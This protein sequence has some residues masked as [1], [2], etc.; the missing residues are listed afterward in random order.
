M[1]RVLIADDHASF[2]RAVSTLLGA[3]DEF[4]VVGTASDGDEAVRRALELQPD[5]VLMDIHMPGLNGID[6]THRITDAAPHIAVLVLTMFDADDSVVAAIRAGARGYLLKGSRQDELAR[7]L[8]AVHAGDAIFGAP[9]AR[10][11][12]ALVDGGRAETPFPELSERERDVLNVLA[13]GANNSAIAQ[14]LALSEKTVRNYVSSI[15]TK[16]AVSTR[17]EAI[18]TARAA[19]LGSAC[20]LER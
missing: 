7:A 19:G 3:M 12:G 2:V 6:A 4:E 16:L 8:R 5:V 13:T 1:I 14:R 10:R 11:L 20:T 9:L 18:V 17:A 15:F